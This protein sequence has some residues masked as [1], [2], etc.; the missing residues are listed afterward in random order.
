MAIR[1]SETRGQLFSLSWTCP[2]LSYGSL[3]ANSSLTRHLRWFILELLHDNGAGFVDLAGHRLAAILSIRNVS[4]PDHLLITMIILITNLEAADNG[5]YLLRK[6][7][8]H[9]CWLEARQVIISGERFFVIH[10]RLCVVLFAGYGSY[11]VVF[12]V[13]TQD[14]A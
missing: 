12:F 10:L 4:W 8:H 9:L 3:K 6:T 7:L 1:V 14:G 2:Y 11:V 5:T 13:F